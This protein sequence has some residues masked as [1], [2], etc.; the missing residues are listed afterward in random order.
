MFNRKK[1]AKKHTQLHHGFVGCVVSSYKNI[2]NNK[3]SSDKT[4]KCF[5]S[6]R[7]VR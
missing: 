3:N 5:S 1:K 7:D 4:F 6:S 2:I